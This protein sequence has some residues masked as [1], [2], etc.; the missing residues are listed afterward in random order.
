MNIYIVGTSGSGKSTLARILAERLKLRHIELD[1]LSFLPGR[2][3]QRPDGEFE[4]SVK[5]AIS[6]DGWV[7]CGNYKNVRPLILDRVDLVVWINYSFAKTFWWTLKRTVKR[8][9]DQSPICNGNYE[10]I[11]IQFFSKKSILWWV[12]TT[13]PKRK[14]TYTALSQELKDKWITIHNPEELDAF[15]VRYTGDYFPVSLNHTI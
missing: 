12:I 10:S 7:I 3:E 15:L 14:R 2:W 4:T 8:I 11:A 5:D 13:Y 6:E 9:Y 1:A